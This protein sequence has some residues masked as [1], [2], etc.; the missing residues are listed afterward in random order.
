[1]TR[2][3]AKLHK[4]EII[5]FA[6]DKTIQWFDVDSQEW[7]DTDD[8]DFELDLK[9][10]IKPATK[11]VPLSADDLGNECITIIPRQPDWDIHNTTYKLQGIT[12]DKQNVIITK[13]INGFT[14]FWI[15]DFEYLRDNFT[16]MDGS[17]FEK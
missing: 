3:G 9:F 13:T 15:I 8:P 17:R 14:H 16:R 11:T 5:A 4:R 6:E 10:R 2:N 1:M 7:I 12:L